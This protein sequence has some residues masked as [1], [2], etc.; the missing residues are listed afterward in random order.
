[1]RPLLWFYDPP[2]AQF[3]HLL[4][5]ALGLLIINLFI[6]NYIPYLLI[7]VF[8]IG[9]SVGYT[10]KYNN[11]L[12]FFLVFASLFICLISTTNHYYQKYVND[13]DIIHNSRSNLIDIINESNLSELETKEM[14]KRIDESFQIMNYIIPFMYF[15]NS[16]IF[17]FLCI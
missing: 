7:T 6:I 8:I 14:H 12:Q 11:T 9:A 4:L 5:L 13:F 10:F 3:Y 16:I 15:L 2:A 1:M 17:S